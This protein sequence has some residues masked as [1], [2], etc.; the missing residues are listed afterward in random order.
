MAPE[1]EGL[2][3]FQDRSQGREGSYG[4]ITGPESK[5]IA[6][7]KA[8]GAVLLLEDSRAVDIVVSTGT[9]REVNRAQI[10]V[11]GPVPSF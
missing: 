6:A 11:S 8:R 2:R 3:Q 7:S 5:L 4:Y 9:A 10:T 1:R